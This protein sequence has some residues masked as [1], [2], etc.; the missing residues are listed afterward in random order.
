MNKNILLLAAGIFLLPACSDPSGSSPAPRTPADVPLVEKPKT[1]RWYSQTQVT[2]GRK[3]FTAYCA[4]CHGTKA[5]SV[6]QWKELDANDNYPPPPLD[7]SAHAWHHPLSVLDQVIRD[8]GAPYGGLMPA[9]GTVLDFEQRLE[10]I[11]SFQHYWSDEIY[12]LWLEREQT[13]REP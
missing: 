8:G 1:D 4:T 9:W 7:G 2:N 3:L 10:V 13:S 6:A 11:A 12:Q 5:A